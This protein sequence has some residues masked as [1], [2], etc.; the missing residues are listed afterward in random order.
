MIENIYMALV[1]FVFWP[2]FFVYLY[3]FY[4]WKDRR[5]KFFGIV[6]GALIWSMV[7]PLTLSVA[8]YKKFQK[9]H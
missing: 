2:L 9:N 5:L 3:F 4:N 1:I 8:A 7:W 6:M